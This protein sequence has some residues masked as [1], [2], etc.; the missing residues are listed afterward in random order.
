MKPKVVIK[1]NL[2]KNGIFKNK[3]FFFDPWNN[4]TI[5]E[6]NIQLINTFIW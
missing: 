5:N 6:L 4:G 2:F 1:I 3:I